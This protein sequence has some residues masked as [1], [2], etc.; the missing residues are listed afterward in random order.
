[1]KDL[2]VVSLDLTAEYIG[3]GSENHLFRQLPDFLS[4]KIKCSFYNRGKQKLSF[5]INKIRFKYSA[6]FQ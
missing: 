1:M 3:I 4:N 6:E 2:E 5:K